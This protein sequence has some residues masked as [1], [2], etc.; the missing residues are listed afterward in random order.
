M[1]QGVEPE[2]RFPEFSGKWKLTPISAL[3]KEADNRK[4][5]K[6]SSGYTELGIRSHGK[7]FIVR[8]N[9]SPNKNVMTHLFEVRTADISIN[10]S[11]AWEG[12]VALA[13]AEH[14]GGLVSH[15]FP[16]FQA[17][18]HL[19]DPNY[20][21][22][23]FKLS[24]FTYRLELYSPGGA[25]RNRVLKKSDLLKSKIHVPSLS[26]QQKI[27]AFLSAVDEK[28]AS[29]KAQLSGWHDYKRGMMQAF[30]SKNLRFKADDGSDFPD[31]KTKALSK[32]VKFEKGR[33]ISKQDITSDGATE[34]IRYGQLYT[35]YRNTI[36]KV[37]SRTNK[38]PTNPILSTGNDVLI[39]SSGE[40]AKDIATAIAILVE[41]VILGGDIN[42]LRTAENAAFLAPYLSS[43]YKIELAKLAQGNAVVHLYSKDMKILKVSLPSLPEQQKIADYLSAIDTKIEALTERLEATQEFKRGLLQKMFV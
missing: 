24:D 25:G 38:A 22:H 26:E 13:S 8:E 15:R 39:P 34:C 23:R 27:V 1:I 18:P 40:D 6:P 19:A 32:F 17:N 41:G 20:L 10:I 36:T 14:E 29:L 12:A 30:F 2:L 43:Y 16:L 33:G 4:V 3:I 9:T 37:V 7:G 35:E 31:W 21:H 28:L 11:F 42:V 5:Q